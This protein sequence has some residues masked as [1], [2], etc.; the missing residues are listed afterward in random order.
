[1][2]WLTGNRFWAAYLVAPLTFLLAVEI[3]KW[4]SN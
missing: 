1:M 3:I 2:K 4:L